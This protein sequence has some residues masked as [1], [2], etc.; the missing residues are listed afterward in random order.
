MADA[1][2]LFSLKTHSLTMLPD[3]S[4][5]FSAPSESAHLAEDTTTTPSDGTHL[6][7]LAWFSIEVARPGL[8]GLPAIQVELL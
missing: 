5:L 2:G 1:S 7:T 4:S 6:A 8:P 3:P